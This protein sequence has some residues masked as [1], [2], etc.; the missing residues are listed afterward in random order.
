MTT[1][2]EAIE[3][4]Q[5]VFTIEPKIMVCFN[6]TADLEKCAVMLNLHHFKR[7]WAQHLRYEVDQITDELMEETGKFVLGQPN[8]FMELSGNFIPDATREQLR[9]ELHREKERGEKTRPLPE[10]AAPESKSGGLF[11][12]LKK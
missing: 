3:D 4:N 12:R 2:T 5:T 11:G 7:P 10:A 1:Y 8:R 6:Y 9:N